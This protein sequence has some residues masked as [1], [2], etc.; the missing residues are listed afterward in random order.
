MPGRVLLR[1]I[2][3]IVMSPSIQNQ[4]TL[5]HPGHSLAVCLCG[6][7]LRPSICRRDFGSV[8]IVT[9]FEKH[10]NVWYLGIFQEHSGL[11]WQAGPFKNRSVTYTREHHHFMSRNGLG[12]GI[13]SQKFE[14]MRDISNR[15]IEI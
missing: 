5:E 4:H 9:S 6:S 8:F 12:P 14:Y 11:G 2:T 1:E 13:L 7:N 10:A 15:W 3:C